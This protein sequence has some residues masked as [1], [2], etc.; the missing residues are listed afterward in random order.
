MYY[1]N[2]FYTMWIMF[3]I[4]CGIMEGMIFAY[5]GGQLNSKEGI[6]TKDGRVLKY[7]YNIHT[8]LVLPRI[9]FSVTIIVLLQVLSQDFLT[10]ALGTFFLFLTFPFFHD[11]SYMQTR[12]FLDYKKYNFFSNSSTTNAVLSLGSWQRSV[13]GLMGLG[14]WWY[15]GGLIYFW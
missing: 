3:S 11:G 2:I 8:A 10:T 4:A 15:Q 1:I 9:V 6:E 12:G 7:P 5:G 14:I 13:L